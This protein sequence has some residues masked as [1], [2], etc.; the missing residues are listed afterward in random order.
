MKRFMKAIAVCALATG[1]A[2]AADQAQVRAHYLDMRMFGQDEMY[3]YFTAECLKAAPQRGPE[4][5]Q[6]LATWRSEN[7]AAI[8][9]GAAAMNRLFPDMGKTEAEAR[10]GIRKQHADSFAAEI[11][12]N[13]D[14]MCWRG[15]Q[16][17]RFAVPSELTG[18]T[19]TDR[20]LRHD[21]FKQAYA[22]AVS[23]SGCSDFDVIDARVTNDLGKGVSRRIEEVW[24]F[25]GCGKEQAATVMHG[26]APAGGTNFVVSFPNPNPNPPPAR[27]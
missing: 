7:G 13:P 23:L 9:R 6:A 22:G 11:A 20:N 4:M 12:A 2:Q 18:T 26:P 24:T 16:N 8:Q 25:K 17:I 21:V 5:Q 19:M 1:V 15:L 14:R 27:P 10:A 3:D